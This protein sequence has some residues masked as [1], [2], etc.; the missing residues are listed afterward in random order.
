[1]QGDYLYVITMGNSLGGDFKIREMNPEGQWQWEK[2]SGV[3]M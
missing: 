3:G 1:M 2:K